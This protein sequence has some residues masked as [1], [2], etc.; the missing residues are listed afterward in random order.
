M[1]RVPRHVDGSGSN[2]L[3]PKI[4]QMVASPG[5]KGTKRAP[6]NRRREKRSGRKYFHDQIMK[7]LRTP[8]PRENQRGKI[9]E[10]DIRELNQ[11]LI[12]AK[13]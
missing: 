10:I 12:R 9:T 8:I 6:D 3:R 11:S 2:P 1:P 7:I 4:S 5:P 13:I